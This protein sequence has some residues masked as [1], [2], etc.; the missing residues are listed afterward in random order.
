MLGRAP[1]GYSSYGGGVRPQAVTA[2]V[3]LAVLTGCSAGGGR[4]SA[5]PDT[6]VVATRT[7]STTAPVPTSVATSE[8]IAEPGDGLAGGWVIAEVAALE[9]VCAPATGRVGSFDCTRY[10]G[11][12]PSAVA[13]VELRCSQR[14]A[15]YDCTSGDYYPSELDGF[16]V[17]E[18]GWARAL[19]RD[20]HCWL[21]PAR[22]TP[23]RATSG[24]PDFRCGW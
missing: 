13:L 11:F 21:W 14:L 16:E 17:A 1:N 10:H 6:T 18:L 8:P 2:M 23:S 22:Q 9:Y 3:A 4:S 15:T 19:R 20:G 7:P 24:A 5:S 12:V